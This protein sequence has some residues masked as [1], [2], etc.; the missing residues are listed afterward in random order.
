VRRLDEVPR[1]PREDEDDV[2][3][4]PLQHHF[5]L[6]AFGANLYEAPRAGIELVGE[7]TEHDSGQEELYVLIAGRARFDLEGESL[8]VAAPGVVAVKDAAVRRSAV[9]L[10]ADTRLL[11]VGA[12]RSGRFAT[13]WRA[14][15]FEGVPTVDAQG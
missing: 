8:E 10:D 4:Y 13:S 15:H 9:A 7:H 14:E 5:G 11:A 1:V 3:W 6:E 2:E 12:P